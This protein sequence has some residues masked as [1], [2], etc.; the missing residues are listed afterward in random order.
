MVDKYEVEAASADGVEGVV[1]DEAISIVDGVTNVRLEFRE[2][3]KPVL[4]HA[5]E[6]VSTAA[7]E[8]EN[9]RRWRDETSDHVTY[10]GCGHA[11]ARMCDR[12]PRS[13]IVFGL[14]NRFCAA[15]R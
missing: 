9:R 3:R 11:R 10:L 4:A 14:R 13:A 2:T 8:V 6:H 12:P 5:E 15:C 1:N 7:T